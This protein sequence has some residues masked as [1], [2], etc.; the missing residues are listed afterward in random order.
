MICGLSSSADFGNGDHIVESEQ[1]ACVINGPTTSSVC[2]LTAF[3][4]NV[5]DQRIGQPQL[6]GLAND[7]VN[8][9]CGACGSAPLSNNDVSQGELTFNGV[10]ET[11]DNGGPF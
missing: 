5:G 1:Q 2:H 10:T 9:G 11:V 3:L 7:I 6:C 4:Q 8:H